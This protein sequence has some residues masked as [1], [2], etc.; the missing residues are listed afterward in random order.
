[1]FGAFVIPDLALF[2]VRIVVGGLM[3]LPVSTTYFRSY[4]KL[5]ELE[6]T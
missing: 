1:L 2:D 5:G 3:E 6:A 4:R